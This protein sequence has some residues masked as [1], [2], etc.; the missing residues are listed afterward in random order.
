MR[1]LILGCIVALLI[2]LTPMTAIG[3]MSAASCKTKVKAAYT[4]RT[5]QTMNEGTFN[6][7][8]DLCQGIIDE[9]KANAELTAAEAAAGIPVS[10][11]TGSGATTAP[12]T[13][14]GKVQ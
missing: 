6:V 11:S 1:P 7:L 3:A 2:T 5:G 4:A 14:T 8:L 13:V 9:I 12:G 10:T